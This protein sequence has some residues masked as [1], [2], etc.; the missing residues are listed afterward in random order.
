MVSP[1][2][3]NEITFMGIHKYASRA[4]LRKAITKNARPDW[5]VRHP[6]RF[7]I[8]RAVLASPPWIKERDFW[9]LVKTRDL[10]TRQTGVKHVLAHI[11]PLSHHKV[12]GLNVPWNIK[13]LTEW[14]NYA[15]SNIWFDEPESLLQRYEQFRLFT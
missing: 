9:S 1:I 6:R 3:T 14:E 15:E 4:S 12:C 5:L 11:V 8:E 7:Y 13:I 10:R 2:A